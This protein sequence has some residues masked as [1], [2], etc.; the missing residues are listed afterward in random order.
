[1]EAR[2]LTREDLSID[3][4]V[5]NSVELGDLLENQDVVLSS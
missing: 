3:V 2:G 5:L 4:E 1:M